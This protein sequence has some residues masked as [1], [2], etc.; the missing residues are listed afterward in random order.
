MGDLEERL[1]AMQGELA[2]KELQRIRLAECL[3]VV[4][5]SEACI[6]ASRNRRDLNT[7]ARN[8]QVAAAIE[9]KN[10]A[11]ERA[12]ITLRSMGL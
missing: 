9:Q 1:N 7:A 3:Q 8:R 10:H 11:L 12:R 2:E 4:L 6:N 5:V